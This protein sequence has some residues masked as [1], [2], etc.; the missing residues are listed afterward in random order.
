MF[1]TGRIVETPAVNGTTK[2]E[3][4]EEKR[5]IAEAK[6]KKARLQ[7]NPQV[8]RPYAVG[9]RGAQPGE[10]AFFANAIVNRLSAPVL[11]EWAWSSPCPDAYSANPPSHPELL[12][13]LARDLVGT[14]TT[15]AA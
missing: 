8:Q 12:S 6:Q 1:L 13:W 10:R 2:E 9:G 14:T 5:L 7:S 15:S 3:L 11:Q 4:K